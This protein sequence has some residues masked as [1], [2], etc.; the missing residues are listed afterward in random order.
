[1]AL[2]TIKKVFLCCVDAETEEEALEEA[3]AFSFD[4]SDSEDT[5]IVSV[6]ASDDSWDEDWD[7]FDEDTEDEPTV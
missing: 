3:D 7:S 1:M 4:G 6:E 2:Y 5:T